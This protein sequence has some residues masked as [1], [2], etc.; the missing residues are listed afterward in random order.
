[1][2]I[3]TTTKIVMDDATLVAITTLTKEIRTKYTAL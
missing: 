2:V 3:G 1:M